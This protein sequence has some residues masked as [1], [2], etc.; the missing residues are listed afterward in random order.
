MTEHVST[1]DFKHLLDDLADDYPFPPHE[2][3]MVEMIANALDAKAS[4]IAIRIDPRA[5]IF[6]IA[7]N[8]TGM[9]LQDFI[10]YH[11]LAVSRKRKGIGI[12]FAGLGAKLGVNL[13]EVVITET[14]MPSYWGASRWF[15]KGDKLIW[16]ESGE[17]TLS[18]NRT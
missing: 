3:L 4:H 18:A 16:T 11:N 14:R 2:A 10:D 1:V 9:S 5:K 13:S 8:G 12:G 6:E 17:R 15:F 7:D